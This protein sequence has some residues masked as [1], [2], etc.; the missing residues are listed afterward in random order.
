MKRKIGSL[1]LALTMLAASLNMTAFAK[2]SDED[3]TLNAQ[4][5]YTNNG[6]TLEKVSHADVAAGSADGFVDYYQYT[7]PDGKICTGVIEHMYA[8]GADTPAIDTAAELAKLRTK[9]ESKYPGATAEQIDGMM[10]EIKESLTGDACQSYAFSAL[11]YG[12]WVY[13]GTMYGGTGITKNNARTMFKSMGL[14]KDETN[15]DGSTNE[16]AVEYNQKL[17]DSA[18]GLLYGD[19]YYTEHP[20]PTQ[21]ILFKMNVKTGE[22]KILMAGSVNGYQVTLRNAVA[23]NGRFYFIGTQVGTESVASAATGIPSIFE[24][25]PEDDSFRTVYQA[26]TMEEYRAMQ[27]AYVFP[28]PRAITVYKGSLIA[29]VTQKDGAHIIA[30]T[31]DADD[32]NADGS[33]K[34]IKVEGSAL[35]N[36]EFTEIAE[37]SEELLNYP[38]YHMYDAN[39]GGT[40]YQ[41]IEYNDKLY[42]AINAGQ[43]ALHS[44][45]NPTEGVYTAVDPDTLEETKCFAGYAILEGTLK[46]GASPSDRSAWTWKPIIGNTADDQWDNSVN[47]ADTDPAMYTFNIDPNRFAAAICTM[48]VY[49]G[50]LYIGDYNDVTQATYPMLQMDFIHLATVLS[51]SVNLYRMDGDYNIELVVGDKTKTFPNGSLSGWESGYTGLNGHGSRINQYTSMTQIWDEDKTD[52]NDGVMLL[53]TLDEGSLLRPMVKI[54]NGDVLKMSE[55]EWAEKISYL[56][57]LIQ[58][59]LD[60]DSSGSNA[61]SGLYK[62]L[63]LPGSTALTPEEEVAKALAAAQ[64]YER[65]FGGQAAAQFGLDGD[66]A[67]SSEKLTLTS[68][69]TAALTE[70]IRSGAIVPHSM[71][72]REIVKLLA[73]PYGMS[74]LSDLLDAS[75]QENVNAFYRVYK[76]LVEYYEKLKESGYVELPEELQKV[77][78]QVL[79]EESARQLNALLTCLNAVSASVVGCD[80]Y[81][82]TTDANGGNLK[83]DVITLD[84]LGDDSNQTMRNF[85][86]TDDYVVFIPGNAIRGGSVYRLTDWP[87]KKEAPTPDPDPTP[88]PKPDP[89][90]DPTPDP[91]PDPDPDPTPDPKPDPTPTPTPTPGSGSALCTLHF[92]TNGGSELADLRVSAGTTVDLKERVTQKAGYTFAGWYTDKELTNAVEKV[93]VSGYTTVYAKWTVKCPFTDVSDRDWFY[94]DVMSMYEKGLMGG[95]SDTAFSP[96]LTTTRGMIVTILYRMENSPA[97]SGKSSFQDVKADAYYNDAVIWAASNGIVTGVSSTEF[98]PDNA[99]TREQFAAILFRY[100]QY[101]GMDA[102]TLEENLGGFADGSTVSAYAVPAMNW[103]VGAGLLRGDDSGLLLPRGEATRAQAAAMLN[104]FIENV[105]K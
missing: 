83:I 73:L 84:G 72:A 94:D 2:Q 82:I 5:T 69:Q 36:S 88:D 92:E 21:G 64:T 4:Y 11:G 60:K 37:Q 91:K 62:G 61:L 50:Y 104:R 54:M 47:H 85:A 24:V 63:D 29:S 3:T 95:T 41:M 80:T 44:T 12:D 99:I 46:D 6:Y 67:A 22:S 40:V 75:G 17:V 76:A 14:L 30:Y 89:D 7:D 15:E 48:E 31:P 74:T 66:K 33:F 55:E 81:A 35:R 105:L 59:L 68:E 96:D 28:I 101:K 25:N 77:L 13:I 86:L 71:S 43:K 56:K 32:F 65:M 58:L 102:V 9:L 79:N 1:L 8:A 98:C 45:L 97:V 51:Q 39:Y 49:N 23:Y 53:G 90:P 87:G 57:V 16:E 100:A 10:A 20:V 78:D 18:V 42:M 93:K 27:A 34:G 70:G 103:A 52:D 38:A 26:V 19:N